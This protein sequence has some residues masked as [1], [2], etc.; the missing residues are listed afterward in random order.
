MPGSISY[1]P[2]AIAT[3]RPAPLQM[4]SRKNERQHEPK[5]PAPGCNEGEDILLRREAAITQGNAPFGPLRAGPLSSLAVWPLEPR[6]MGGADGGIV[7][8]P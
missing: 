4:E 5:S 3:K 2:T 7:V 6:T 1:R 8:L